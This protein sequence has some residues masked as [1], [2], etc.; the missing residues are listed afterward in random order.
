MITIK[1]TGSDSNMSHFLQF[2]GYFD[3]YLDGA[4]TPTLTLTDEEVT[5]IVTL[6]LLQ[7]KLIAQTTQRVASTLP[8]GRRLQNVHKPLRAYPG[9]LEKPSQPR[10]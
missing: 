1:H 6:H 7:V 2:G 10:R 4:L 3:V 8:P 5:Q 9:D